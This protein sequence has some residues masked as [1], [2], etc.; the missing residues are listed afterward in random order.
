MYVQCA[1]A[2]KGP[3]NAQFNEASSNVLIF[4]QIPRTTRTAITITTTSTAQ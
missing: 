4:T 1:N 3:C 2:S